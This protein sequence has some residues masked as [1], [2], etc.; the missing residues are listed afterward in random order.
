[1]QQDV[2]NAVHLYYGLHRNMFTLL[3]V[4]AQHSSPYFYCPSPGGICILSRTGFLEM[5][6][7]ILSGWSLFISASSSI[8]SS[9]SISYVLLFL[10]KSLVFLSI[11]QPSPRVNHTLVL[12]F[13]SHTL[14]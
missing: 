10:A 13:P 5:S 1:M 9:R 6:G 12:P 4:W 3:A 2:R 14:P 7:C 11:A 8:L